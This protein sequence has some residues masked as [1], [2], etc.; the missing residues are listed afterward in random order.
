MGIVGHLFVVDNKLCLEFFF[1]PTQWSKYFREFFWYIAFAPTR[2]GDVPL[3]QPEFSERAA[4]ISKFFS[5]FFGQDRCRV[6]VIMNF[7][8]IGNIGRDVIEDWSH[9]FSLRWFAQNYIY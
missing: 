7:V 5:I 1:F 3:R 6:V 2:F 4:D 8:K 9:T